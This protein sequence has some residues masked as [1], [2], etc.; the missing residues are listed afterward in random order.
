M[1]D[2]SDGLAKDLRALT[3]ANAEPSIMANCVPISLAA[4]H[5]AKK[6]GRPSL[7]HALSDGEDY[8]LLFIVKKSADHD[9]FAHAWRRRFKTPLTYL[10]RFVRRGQ[11]APGAIDLNNYH[12]YEHLR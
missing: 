4:I 5:L 1:I 2:L 8:E 12:G 10:G 11:R 9:A 3:P 6:S 7:A